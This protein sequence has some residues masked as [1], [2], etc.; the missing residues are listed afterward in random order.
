MAKTL[1]A[2]SIPLYPRGLHNIYN[3]VQH[4]HFPTEQQL[5]WKHWVRSIPLTWYVV[6]CPNW[7]YAP[8]KDPGTQNFWEQVKPSYIPN[9]IRAFPQ[10]VRWPNIPRG[11]KA[12]RF[13]ISNA[14]K[15]N[16]GIHR[17]GRSDIQRLAW[18]TSIWSC[19]KK[20][21]SKRQRKTLHFNVPTNCTENNCLKTTLEFINHFLSSFNA[22]I[23][24]AWIPGEK[25]RPKNSFPHERGKKTKKGIKKRFRTA[26]FF[27]HKTRLFSSEIL[28]KKTYSKNIQ[29][30][31]RKKGE[32]ITITIITITTK[33]TTAAVIVPCIIDH[34]SKVPHML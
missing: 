11:G 9:T 21:T 8:E 26:R 14:F 16:T 33:K 23:K 12:W 30:R 32:I 17:F 22:T 3:G 25:R 5:R 31:I 10:S 34:I 7:T 4:K 1:T 29:Q 15:G 24:K 20:T 6:F 28:A 19:S 13:G 2:P 18:K 27:L